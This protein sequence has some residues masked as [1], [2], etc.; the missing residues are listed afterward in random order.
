MSLVRNPDGTY[1]G[2]AA[3]AR[4]SGLSEDEVA[5]TFNRIQRLMGREK[6]SKEETLAI[7]AEEA[8]LK[9]WIKS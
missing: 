2:V 7:V 5:W 3:M 1:N 4:M 6:R 8:K 9:P